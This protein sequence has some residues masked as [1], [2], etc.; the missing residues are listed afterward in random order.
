MH[1]DL[2]AKSLPSISKDLRIARVTPA[3][4][5]SSPGFWKQW[6]YW[7]HWIT[8]CVTNSNDKDMSADAFL[9]PGSA[10]PHSCSILL[11]LGGC[12]IVSALFGFN[13]VSITCS[14]M[15]NDQ[16]IFAAPSQFLRCLRSTLYL[17]VRVLLADCPSLCAR[18][19]LDCQSWWISS[20]RAYNDDEA[21]IFFSD[22]DMHVLSFLFLSAFRLYISY[23]LFWCWIACTSVHILLYFLV[24]KYLY[25]LAMLYL[26]ANFFHTRCHLSSL[27]LPVYCVCSPA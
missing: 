25:Y 17:S 11:L 1:L 23:L 22:T 19:V 9:S 18:D 24:L 15:K 20:E 26:R 21:P 2:L 7:H 8:S 10:S 4:T 16:Q 13:S 3:S 27:F 12:S 5:A 14:S 6:D